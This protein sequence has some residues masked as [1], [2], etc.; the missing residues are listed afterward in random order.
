MKCIVLAFSNL[1]DLPA[2]KAAF[3]IIDCYGEVELNMPKQTDTNITIHQELF[4]IG[5]NTLPETPYQEAFI[6][7]PDPWGEPRNWIQAIAALGECLQGKLICEF[8]YP[9]E[10]IAFH[11]LLVSL[12]SPEQVK[13]IEATQVA[14][15]NDWD[16]FSASWH[17]NAISLQA[18]MLEHYQ[19]EKQN[20]LQRFY[21]Q[22]G[23][24]YREISLEEAITIIN[25]LN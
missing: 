5:K 22:V 7:H 14:D 24:F 9:H 18:N 12:L 15:C 16:N 4:A 25:Q 2:N 3:E 11:F 21:K 10:I 17:F 1:S 20:I 19:K 8:W 6:R 13:F 23:K